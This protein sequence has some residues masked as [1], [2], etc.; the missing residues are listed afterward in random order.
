M[1]T[2]G[3]RSLEKH[4]L[5]HTTGLRHGRAHPLLQRTPDS[6]REAAGP[7][8]LIP[9]VGKPDETKICLYDSAL[10]AKLSDCVFALQFVSRRPS[11]QAY[12]RIVSAWPHLE[13]VYGGTCAPYLT[14]ARLV[15][16]LATVG[17]EASVESKQ[18]S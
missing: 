10:S 7:C 17:I 5:I 16:F 14:T 3:G 11:H 6:S 9:R 15:E 13:K 4:R 2:V 12:R 1:H 18:A 8:I